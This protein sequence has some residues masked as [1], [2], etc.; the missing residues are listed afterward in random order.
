MSSLSTKEKQFLEKL[1]QMDGG[2]VLNFTNWN[3]KEFFTD[4]L[5][6]DFYDEAFNVGSGSKAW[7]MRGF[8]KK[9]DDATVG[10]SILKL[11]DYI[12]GQIVLDQLKAED[13]KPSL[14]D[15]CRKIAER[16]LRNAGSSAVGEEDPAKVEAFLQQ[17]FKDVNAAIRDLEADIQKVVK[18]RI[19]EIEAI[20]TIAPLAAIFLIGSTLEGILLDVAK[21]DAQQF[22]AASSAPTVKGKV[23]EI[24]GWR[25]NDLI[26]VAYE[27]GYVTKN[28]HDFSHSLREF[29]NYIHP[30]AQAEAAFAPD[31]ST[32]KICF[33]VLKAALTEVRAKVGPTGTEL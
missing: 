10:K 16:L 8:W 7:Q 29:R 21:R 19:S 31:V 22:M 17:D 28:V 13:F 27:L 1:F 26:K 25:L 6:V 20:L 9:A 15:A 12:D 11:L 2:Y 4:E 32:A 14:V 24:D 33:Q 3:I 23:V 30:R 18:Q 5:G